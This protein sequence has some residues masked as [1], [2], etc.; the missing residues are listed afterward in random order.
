MAVTRKDVAHKA[1][2]STATVSN[3]IN[4]HGAVGDEVK[5]RVL[6]VISELG[7]QPNQ[8]ARSLKTKQTNE[9]A[10]FSSDIMN[11][12]YA[13]V[14]CGIEE[15]ARSR[16]Y[17]VCIVT[18]DIS[19]ENKQAFFNRQF[20][21]IIVQSIH[22]SV[23]DLV[24]LSERN[25]PLV[26]ISGSEAWNGIPPAVTQ[27]TIEIKRGA[28]KLF[29]YLI[30]QGHRNIAF[31]ASQ[32]IEGAR[33]NDARLEAYREVLALNDIVYDLSNVYTRELDH[34]KIYQFV[35]HLMKKK[36]PPTAIFAGND[37]SA[38]IVLAAVHN[39]GL[40]VPKDVSVA[41]FDNTVS[42][43]YYYPSLTTVG[44]PTYDLGRAAAEILFRK[45]SGET[46]HDTVIKT[47][48]VIRNSTSAGYRI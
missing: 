23:N 7:Y 14:A 29:Q 13:E 8:I 22:I 15:Y 16:G 35:Q 28:E 21:G 42:S 48:L 25:I 20:D 27:L 39:L 10:L 9:I 37:H 1:H 26:L 38:L 4:G 5:K 3:V 31:I 2:V 47:D 46:I 40:S 43:A 36:E 6:E 44:I 33:N 12:Y 41:G 19:E 30:R 34:D 18:S 17:M 32:A 11:P 45:I 24:N